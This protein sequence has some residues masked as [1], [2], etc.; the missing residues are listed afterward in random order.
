MK[1]KR[2]Q[3]GRS[4]KDLPGF[5]RGRADGAGTAHRP[6]PSEADELD[7]NVLRADYNAIRL[8]GGNAMPTPRDGLPF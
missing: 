7:P 6:V 2:Q 4:L 8:A 3:M 1:A 5:R